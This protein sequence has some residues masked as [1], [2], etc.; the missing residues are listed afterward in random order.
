[1]EDEGE[2]RGVDVL[3]LVAPQDLILKHHE[4]PQYRLVYGSSQMDEEAEM[5][6]A[7]QLPGSLE[8]RTCQPCCS[9]ERSGTVTRQRDELA[10][11]LPDGLVSERFQ[12]SC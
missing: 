7:S 8:R 2:V 1:M 11:D 4:V 6:L 9:N 5:L 12:A 3:G 10:E